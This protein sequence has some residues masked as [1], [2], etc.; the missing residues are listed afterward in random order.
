[1]GVVGCDATEVTAGEAPRLLFG[2]GGGSSSFSGV[3]RS[4]QAPFW[5]GWVRVGGWPVWACGGCCGLCGGVTGLGL[6]AGSCG[7]VWGVRFWGC[8]EPVGGVGVAS[9]RSGF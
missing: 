4:C 3:W 7:G 2:V 6:V 5:G 8:L 9:W 1:V